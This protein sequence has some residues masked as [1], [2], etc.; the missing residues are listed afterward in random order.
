M[1]DWIPCCTLQQ[2]Q[3]QD[4]TNI[5]TEEC[6]KLKG[7][8]LNPGKCD[9]RTSCVSAVT[10]KKNGEYIDFEMMMRMQGDKPQY[11]AVGFSKDSSMVG[12]PFVHTH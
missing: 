9:P 1:I 6:G 8:F 11:V 7:C 10:W 12:A 2:C 5:S 4:I 3:G